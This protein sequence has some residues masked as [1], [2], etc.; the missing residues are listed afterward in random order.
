[1]EA[2]RISKDTKMTFTTI[3][4]VIFDP[5]AS[6]VLLTSS[7]PMLTAALDICLECGTVYA[8]KV[9]KGLARIEIER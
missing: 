1:M 7:C 6:G 3:K 2:G 8:F 9:A 5:K 4:S